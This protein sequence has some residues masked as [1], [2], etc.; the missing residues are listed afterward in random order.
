MLVNVDVHRPARRLQRRGAILP[1]VAISLIALL[2][3]VARALGVG[4]LLV[5][6][7]QAQ[8]VADTAAMTGA[9]S[10][11]GSPGGNLANAILYA[12]QIAGYNVVLGIP[13]SSSEMTITPGAYHYDPV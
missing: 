4:M 12:Q 13:V 2:G 1:M 5:A 10:I 11:D 6:K 9:R 3:L 8:N 7:T